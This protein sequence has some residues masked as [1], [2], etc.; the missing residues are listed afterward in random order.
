MCVARN[1]RHGVEISSF[2]VVECLVYPLIPTL[3]RTGHAHT[4]KTHAPRSPTQIHRTTKPATNRRSDRLIVVVVSACNIW[5]IYLIVPPLP[6][7]FRDYPAA[8]S[9]PA[10]IAENPECIWG[11]RWARD[12][13][14]LNV[15]SHAAAPNMSFSVRMAFML[16]SCR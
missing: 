2:S 1:P 12:R 16:L 3:Q 6:A 14:S 13:V 10:G 5:R 7:H 8:C 15:D 11:Y 9:V 4:S